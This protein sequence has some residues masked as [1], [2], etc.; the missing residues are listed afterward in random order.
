MQTRV[1]ILGCG[2]LG[3][4][5]AGQLAAAG[6]QVNGAT[7]RKEKMADIVAQQATP[8]VIKLTPD[9]EGDIKDF[10]QADILFINVP[11]SR[12][13]DGQPLFYLRQMQ[14]L[15]PHIEPHQSIK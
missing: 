15:I 4:P 8:F 10:L 1:S 5:L 3:M 11:P 2:W 9:V 13:G 14:A 7:T 12:T 6:Y